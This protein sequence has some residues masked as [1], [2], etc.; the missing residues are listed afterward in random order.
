MSEIGIAVADGEPLPAMATAQ[1]FVAF[2]KATPSIAHT[3]RGVSGVH[4]AQLI[5]QFDLAD[6]VKPKAPLVD[7][8][9]GT[10]VKD[11]KVAAAV[12]QISELKFAGAGNIVPLPREIQVQTVFTVAVLNGTARRRSRGHR[13]RVDRVGSLPRPS[14]RVSERAYLTDFSNHLVVVFGILRRCTRSAARSLE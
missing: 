5:E 6:V 11:G 2:M 10:L 8:F 13:S 9:S 12:Q 1:D 4:M 7:G 3:V 14:A